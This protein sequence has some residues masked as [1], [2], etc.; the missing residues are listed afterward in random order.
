MSQFVTAFEQKVGEIFL[1]T[2]LIGFFCC[3]LKSN[4]CTNNNTLL[5]SLFIIFITWFISEIHEPKK[6]YYLSYS[7]VTVDFLISYSCLFPVL[8][9]NIYF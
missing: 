3:N 1:T 8:A 5:L 6:I 4:T 9:L 2:K 7:E